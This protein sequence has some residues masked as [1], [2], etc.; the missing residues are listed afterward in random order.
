MVFIDLSHTIT[1]GLITYPGLPAPSI[2]TH[3]S[4]ADSEATYVDGSHF[5]ITEITMVA[6]T[7]TYLDT[8]GHRFP[9]G[10]DLADIELE[11]VAHLP[12]V[13]IDATSHGEREVPLELLPGR[14]LGGY[15]VLV[16]T[17][18]SRHFGERAY[19]QDAP[20]V[21]EGLCDALIELGVEIVGIDSLNIDRT[22]T[23]E[24]PVHTKLL[25]AEILPV[26][27]LTNLAAIDAAAPFRF[28]A[29]PP[30]VRGMGT[31]PVRAFAI[32]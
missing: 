26:E 15:A 14:E 25:A 12:G 9:G 10:D 23:G 19:T 8:P 30:R 4:F 32:Q 11:Q 5:E 29:V 22:D 28:F 24:R 27:H 31:F 17:G 7:G 16:H 3:L 2:R 21:G 1:D 13:V 6:N 20:Y 18:W